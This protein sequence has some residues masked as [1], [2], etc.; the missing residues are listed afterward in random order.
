MWTYDFIYYVM[1]EF[2]TII[3][4]ATMSC[5]LRKSMICMTYIQ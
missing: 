1:V 2:D 3:A 5:I 4:L